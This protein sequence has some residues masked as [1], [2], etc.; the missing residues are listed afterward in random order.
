MILFIQ[1]KLNDVLNINN[2]SD[3]PHACKEYGIIEKQMR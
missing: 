1:N 3:V 2:I